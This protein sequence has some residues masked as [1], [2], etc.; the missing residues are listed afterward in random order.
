MGSIRANG[1]A[2]CDPCSAIFAPSWPHGAAKQ[3]ECGNAALL[4]AAR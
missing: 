2:G 3:L 1:Q 4:E